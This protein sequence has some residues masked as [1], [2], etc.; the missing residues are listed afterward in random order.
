MSSSSARTTAAAALATTLW[1]GLLA[2]W[3][4][5]GWILAQGIVHPRVT[6]EMIRTSRHIGWMTPA[7]D[8]LIFGG[9]GILLGL[10]A[11]VWNRFAGWTVLR[12]PVALGCLTILLN[13][14][15]LY[16]ASSVILACGTAA[17]AGRWLE[18]RREAFNRLVRISLPALAVGS[19]AAAG[20]TYE[21]VRTAE[22][23]AWSRSPT[24]RPGAPNVLL[25]VLD[26]VRASCL[27]L[28]GRHRPTSPNLERLAERGVVF[29]EARATAPWTSPT[30]ASLMTGR[31]AHE[32]SVGPDRPL[33]STHPTLAEVLGREGYATAGFVGNI[34]YCTALL[35]LD[36]GFARYEDAYENQTVSP[37]EI[38][39]SSGL[40]RRTARALGYS[41]QLEDGV[42]LRR[43][44]AAMINA[45]VLN[46]LEAKPADRPF[47]VFINYYDAHRPYQ[48]DEITGPRFGASALPAAEQ[49]KIDGRFQDMT[50]GKPIPA[51]YTADQITREGVHL[52]HDCYDSCIAY[53][54]AQLG[55][56]LGELERRGR[57]EN[58]L[59]IVTSDHGE[60]LGEHGLVS[61]GASV[62][63]EEVHV[64]LLVVPP[65]PARASRIVAEPVSLRDVPATVAEWVPLGAPSPFPGRSLTRFLN[66]STAD[67]ADDSPVLSEL[68]HNIV[69]PPP[70]PIPAPFGPARSL[71]TRDLVYIRRGDGGEELYDAANDALE[72]VNR[73]MDPRLRPALDQF[74]DAMSRHPGGSTP[75]YR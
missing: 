64:P 54:D 63:R 19:A 50:A 29:T 51:G 30:H 47:F 31:W 75:R 48:L 58:T 52:F 14:E 45:D 55:R 18:R 24:A 22:Q 62:H 5:I 49:S 74:R 66:V 11:R 60:Q 27:S 28:Y 17:V 61:H 57:L 68:E 73:V 46:W 20:L 70:M 2:G 59:V 69:F 23:R 38:L 41:T 56:L 37:F 4:E 32:L 72:I 44:T 42:T 16:T 10:I 65:S 13:V 6:P 8:F 7:A 39:W 43:K 15:G 25:I 40:G 33:D 1:F 21:R 12:L 3:L 67:S 35:G 9:V 36:R 53:I 26:T 34:Y 71:T